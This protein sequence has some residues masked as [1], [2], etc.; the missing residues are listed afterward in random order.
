MKSPL[1]LFCFS[2]LLFTGLWALWSCDNNSSKNLL[3]KNLPGLVVAEQM[4]NRSSYDS[5][6]IFFREVAD[7]NLKSNRYAEWLKGVSGLIDCYRS[8]GDL[9]EAMRLAD[10][11]LAIATNKVDTAG[12]IFNSLIQKK[13]SL[14][15]DK[16]QFDPAVALYNRNIRIYSSGSATPDTGLAMAYNGMGT[17]NLLQNKY[18]EA[19]GE[20]YK[21]IEVYEKIS[22]TRNV[23]YTG[24]LQ[25]IGIVYS[26]TGNYE[27][28]E[29]YFLK[30]LKVNQELLKSEDP[31]LATL[32][33][34]MGRFY[35]IVRNDSKAIEFM[36]QAEKIYLSQNQ[37]NSIPAG[38]LFL[39][40]GVMYIYTADFEKAQ[41]YFDKS[42]EIILA[43]APGNKADL[44]T[45]YLNK[46]LIAEKK[47]EF[48]SSKNYY[49]KGLSIGDKLPNSVKVLRGLANVSF[50]MS[51]KT[52]AHAYYKM[53]LKKSIEM[54]G[55]Q[56]PE[57]AL[58]YLRY[59][60]F[61]SMTGAKQALVYLNK[62]LNLYKKSF[63]NVNIDVST[64]YNY[65]GSYYSRIH[66]FNK[67]VSYF[68]LS[69]IAGFSSFTSNNISDNPEILS[70]NLNEN[71]LNTLTYKATALLSLYLSDT[72]R[73]DLLKN[74]VASYTL[75]LKM[76]EMLRSTYQDENSKL[77]I[78]ENEKTT[79]TNALLSQV[80][81]YRKTQN[82]AALDE[83]F[84]LSEKGK[85]AVLLS[86]LRDKEA[87]SIGRIPENLLNQDASLK[88]EIYFYNKQ[89]H[90]QK[91]TANPDD[92]K[93]KMWNSRIFD[94]SRKQDELI[95][96]IEKNY[97]A[98]YNLK[99]DNSV[100]SINDIQKKLSPEQA[101]IE[102]TLTDSTLYTFA[103]TS[104]SKQ[105]VNTSIDSS[106]F[107]NLQIVRAQLTGK[108]FNNYTA[109]D[110]KA[111]I[112]S[113]YGL[114]QK[115]LYPIQPLIKGKE[116]IIIPDGELGY[117]SFD[118]LL[119]SLPEISKPSYRKLPYLIKESAISYA[120]SATTFFDELKRKN[121]KNNGRIL[122]FGPGYGADNA[123]LNQ[124]D[125]N[126]RLLK[127]TLSNLTNT[128]DEIKNLKEYFNVK[129]YL[130]KDATETTFKKT[131]SDYR[132]LHLA[133]HTIINNENPL[134]SK[135]IFDKQK[136]DT[137][138][139]GML[140]AS[141]L[142]NM[143][144]H[145]DMAVL[146]ACNTGSGKM[147]KGEGIMSLSRDFFYAGVPGII[148]TSW[149][150]EDRSGVKLMENFYRYIAQGK[151]RH[152]ALR[153]AKIEYLENCDKL[154]AHPHY[155]AAY[156]NVGD[157]SPL[158]GFGKKTTSFSLYGAAATLFC[159][160]ILLLV[161]LIRKKNRNK[162]SSD[163]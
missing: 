18:T 82:P 71:L 75:S 51:D 42:L 148:M 135:L 159:I 12:N 112:N 13:A 126:G 78:S 145:A 57:T 41:N 16:R 157:I 101:I 138:D 76:V 150:V 61:L 88:S 124:K 92:A 3:V 151:P 79:F 116:L 31:R 89:I 33:L 48:A 32:Y 62:S 108:D 139:D 36:K 66:D 67:A 60:E 56:H 94:L 38:S 136:G 147:R 43:K 19:L 156:M 117:L 10:Q 70:D 74:C 28:A 158:Q 98:Y 72:T 100:I 127:N 25:N 115:L 121:I 45:L 46:G 26:I 6:I 144:L 105:L 131:A 91:I 15:S 86:H 95:K 54:Y 85:S 103:I 153:L 14:F 163:I 50:K 160:A 49:L 77:F 93:I 104:S 73:T 129:A 24:T 37:S 34:N 39:N 109:A 29:Q 52:D 90:D 35:Q 83:A 119:T 17:V 80:K 2:F 40:M 128:R 96:S 110:F 11:A 130:G 53:A 9:D 140:N 99:Y 47:G 143:E 102:F 1:A 141:E 133:M 154:T 63:G 20:Y 152:E 97:P 22:H 87:K 149:A 137:I 55:E 123:A 44:L 161:Y 59:G 107:S 125:E 30:S 64:A 162:R 23:N 146:S 111:F 118:I 4:K 132:V 68:Q 21:A 65:I 122:A 134:Y 84:S 114:Y 113:S 120:P 27:K 58:T 155:W 7:S 81:L 5:A 142:I 8:K 106:F 69:L